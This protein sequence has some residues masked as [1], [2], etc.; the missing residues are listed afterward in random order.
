MLFL[1]YLLFS[2][3][4]E[5]CIFQ[6][7]LINSDF[8]SWTFTIDSRFICLADSK[9]E[10]P[11]PVATLVFDVYRRGNFAKS[12]WIKYDFLTKQNHQCYFECYGRNQSSYLHSSSSRNA[13]QLIQPR[14]FQQSLC[15]WWNRDHL[16][17]FWFKDHQKH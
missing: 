17:T 7:T 10:V 8:V 14:F 2:L 4:I 16:L 5:T 9:F 1:L 3:L 13:N 12:I 11:F 6:L 15:N